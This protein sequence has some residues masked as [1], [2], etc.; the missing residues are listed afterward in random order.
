MSTTDFHVGVVV[1]TFQ[2]LQSFNFLCDAQISLA[3]PPALKQ[4]LVE[5]H[6]A[7]RKEGKVLPVPRTPC[8]EEVLASY[9][10][11]R[12]ASA[13]ADTDAQ[14]VANGLRTYFDRSLALVRLNRVF[15]SLW[16]IRREPGLHCRSMQSKV[17]SKVLPNF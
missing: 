3:I 6:D 11:S 2:H 16:L 9:V 7:V 14:Q 17:L 12:P 5:D 1:L 15:L 10:R 4:K 13:T 8:V